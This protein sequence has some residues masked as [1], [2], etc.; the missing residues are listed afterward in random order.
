MTSLTV[1]GLR[2]GDSNHLNCETYGVDGALSVA[3]DMRAD[4][5]VSE[6]L[7]L[8]PDTAVLFRWVR[9]P[10]STTWQKV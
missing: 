4:R 9:A 2:S 5:S 10:G 3:R 8:D 1:R 7:I 6:V